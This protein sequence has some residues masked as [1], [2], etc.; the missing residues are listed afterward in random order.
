MLP[1]APARLLAALVL[2]SGVLAAGCDSALDPEPFGIETLE[3]QLSSPAGAVPFANSFY[4]PM[5]GLYGSFGAPMALA[6]ESSTD[7]GWAFAQ[8]AGTYKERDVTGSEGEFNAIWGKS[9]GDGIGRANIYLDA[10]GDIDWTGEEDLR[11]QLQGEAYFFRAFYYFNLVRIFGEVPIYTERL[12]SVADA[13]QPR[14]P[15]ADVYAQIKEDA[16]R[17]IDL[18]PEGHA[19]NG[20]LGQERGRVTSGAARTLL[21]KVHLTLEEWD[22]VISVTDPVVGAYSLRPNYIDNFYGLLLD[23]SGENRD[24]SIF[25]VQYAEQGVGPQHQLRVSYTPAGVR[26]GQNQILPT[27]SGYLE[28]QPGAYGDNAFVQA[29]ED[30]DERFDVLLSKFGSTRPPVTGTFPERDAS[31]EIVRDGSG[32]IVFDREWFVLKWYSEISNQETR[33][34][35][36][37]FRYAEVLLMRAEAYAENGDTGSAVALVNEI[38]Q[39]AGLDNLEAEDSDE[40]DEVIA[41]VRKER[42]TELGFEFKRFFD[43]NR[44]GILADEVAEQGVTIP[45]SKITTHPIT[46]KP[47][48]LWPIPSSELQRNPNASQNAG[49]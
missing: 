5:Q 24:E 11:A 15:V 6:L 26:D 1:R 3:S 8:F 14:D 46:G 38:R 34:N 43:L 17:A 31:G 12:R 41:A 23:T 29:F 39:R 27:D 32:N 47:E 16:R 45:G 4:E 33:W 9:L 19:N 22:D 49:Y 35:I 40:Q 42:R 25:E 37:V 2:A 7:D 13:Q 36:P 18:L 48:V 10:E 28:S 21:G 20:D 30:G 44:W